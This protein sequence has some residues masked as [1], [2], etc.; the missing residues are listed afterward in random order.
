M[1]R[2]AGQLISRGP[3]T[4]LVRVSLGC[5]PKTGTGKSAT[6][7]FGARSAKRKATSAENC[8][9]ARLDAFPVR[10]RYVLSS[11]WISGSQR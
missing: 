9:N 4:W 5:D 8:K 3:R 1:A 7:P 11:T 10:R 2:K 6:R